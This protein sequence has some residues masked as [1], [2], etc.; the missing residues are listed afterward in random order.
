VRDG[1][2]TGTEE[3]RCDYNYSGPYTNVC[4][5]VTETITWTGC[6]GSRAEPLDEQLG[7]LATRYPGMVNTDCVSQMVD[8]SNDESKLNSAIDGMVTNGD[9]YIPQGLLWGWN[10]LDE[11]K[12]LDNAKS[13]GAISAM[14]GSKS[15][16]LMSDGTNTLAP[17]APHH[18]GADPGDSARGA[19]KM[20]LLC[21]KIKDD[22]IV[23][24]TVSFMISDAPTRT[25]MT[26]CAS[27]P[28]KA[29]TADTALE[30]SQAFKEIGASLAS[31]RLTK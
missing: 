18:W 11:N 15:I 3:R 23:I 14:G 19:A 7:A 29:F 6:V 25:R 10:M 1:V 20:E 21:Q 26:D 22:G 12:P 30:L 9:T 28:S 27:Q 5:P 16:I 24:Y 17:Y 31:L 13:K 2:N 4:T 8:L